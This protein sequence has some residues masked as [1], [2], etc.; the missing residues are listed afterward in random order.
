M[1]ECGLVLQTLFKFLGASPDGLVYDASADEKF[2]LLEVKCPYLP[3][4][5]R[6]TIED[7]CKEPSFGCEL[8]GGVV[9]LK[10]QHAFKFKA[11][12]PY[13][14]LCGATLCYGS[15]SRCTYNV[16]TLIKLLAKQDVCSPC[17]FFQLLP[18]YS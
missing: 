6:F 18:G 10:R 5:E 3:F 15:A 11:S 7:A 12:L 1:Q 4:T 16:S 8:L 14:Q 9:R 13:I 2:G 17:I